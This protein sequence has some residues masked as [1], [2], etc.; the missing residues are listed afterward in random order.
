MFIVFEGL[1]GS[2][3]TTQSAFLGDHLRMRGH[4]VVLTREPSEGPVG[5]MIRQALRRRL[6]MSSGEA[7]DDRMLALMFAADRIDHIRSVVEPAIA[8]KSI[9]ISDRYVHSSLAY[10]GATL[11]MRWVDAINAQA[12]IADLV[13]WVDVPVEECLQ[14]MALRGGEA[15]LF[16]NRRALESILARYEEALAL[17]P[18]RTIRIDGT[19]S[20][21]DVRS[22]IMAAIASVFPELV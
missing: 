5:V 17:R 20:V 7:L 14:R 10:Q 12:R 4:Q 6:V 9:V 21:E 2:G 3:T 11:D 8:R 15:E 18:E 16:E 19:G 1:D 22:R 13:L